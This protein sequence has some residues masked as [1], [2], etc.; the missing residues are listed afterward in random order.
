RLRGRVHVG[1]LRRH[2]LLG[3]SQGGDRRCIHDTGTEPDTRVLPQ[4]VQVAR[5]SGAR[6]LKSSPYPPWIPN[7][8]A[9]ASRC[10]AIQYS[11]RC[12]PVSTLAAMAS[13]ALTT[14]SN[15]LPDT[16]GASRLST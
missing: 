6:G 8:E 13:G 9:A 2:L 5:L 3:R 16:G 14:S 4:D 11:S 7:S 1:W 10:L 15:C 12:E